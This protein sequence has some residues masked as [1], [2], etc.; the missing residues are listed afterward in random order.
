MKIE[1]IVVNDR[2]TVYTKD[3]TIYDTEKGEDIPQEVFK[4]VDKISKTDIPCPDCTTLLT[5]GNMY[6]DKAELKSG[7]YCEQCG[8]QNV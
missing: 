4:L 8:Y 2:Y 7:L 3:W 6:T 1:K 5:G